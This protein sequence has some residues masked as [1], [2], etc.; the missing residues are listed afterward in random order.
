MKESTQALTE[1]GKMID[2]ERRKEWEK[3]VREGGSEGG[4][5]GAREEGGSEGGG[6]EEGG[7]EGVHV[8]GWA[9]G[10]SVKLICCS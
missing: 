8:Q 7:R 2:R 4:R 5:E 1:A 9:C 10:P 6:R 3:G